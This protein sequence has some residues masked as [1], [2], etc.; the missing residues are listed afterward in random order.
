MNT[1][2]K[3][4]ETQKERDFIEPSNLKHFKVRHAIRTL[5]SLF[6]VNDNYLLD[7]L[8]LLLSLKPSQ[9][10][11]YF[12][13]SFRFELGLLHYQD[14]LFA[15]CNSI[16]IF[17]QFAWKCLFLCSPFRTY[18]LNTNCLRAV[19]ALSAFGFEEQYL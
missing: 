12:R 1:S 2:E 16:V 10:N 19:S 11:G 18:F 8:F 14:G 9:S 17:K 13:S 3:E 15:L 6:S 7:F 4:K 5:F